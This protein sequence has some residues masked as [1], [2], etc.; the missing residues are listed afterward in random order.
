[1]GPVVAP[2]A[3]HAAKIRALDLATL[4]KR[5]LCKL[6]QWT[7]PDTA[8]DLVQAAVLSLIHDGATTWDPVADPDAWRFVLRHTTE[9]RKGARKKATRR[10]TDLDTDSV[11]AAPP[12]S[13]PGAQRVALDREQAARA[14]DDLL[15][16]LH[17]NALAVKVVQLC[18]AE[19]ELKPA[20]IAERL[21]EDVKRIYRC[22]RRIQAELAAMFAADR[23]AGAGQEAYT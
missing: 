4:R 13:D 23:L 9:A 21:R 11:E 19:G 15:R 6:S 10:R 14:R 20:E 17:D 8:E 2:F 7:A 3:L 22:Q 1:M 12:S 5:L 18:I 16:R